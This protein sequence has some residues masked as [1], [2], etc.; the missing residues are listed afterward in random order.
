[1]SYINNP[2]IVT[3]G[4]VLSLDASDLNSYVSGSSTW[5][6]LS[7]NN[8]NGTL[9]N[10][11]RFQPT[12]SL[13]AIVFDGS[14]SFVS[15]TENANMTPQVLS[16]EA[17]FRVNS[18]TNSSYGGAPLTFQ[19][20]VFRQN[21]RIASFE[22][23]NLIYNEP[24]STLPNSVSVLCINAA[25]SGASVNSTTSSVFIGNTYTIAV[26]LNTTLTSIYING[27]FNTSG[28]KPSGLDY[29]VNHTLKLGRAVPTGTTFDMAFNGQ[30]Y[31]F[32]LY[33]RVL[34][35]SEVLQNYL[36]QKSKFDF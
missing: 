35:A 32:K 6:D 20:I 14:G 11:C 23:Y 10:S 25:G 5:S 12:S 1:M 2:K 16:F 9:F 17:T 34:S 22:G 15:I 24:T 21:S 4:L 18:A 7:G 28:T 8:N 31:N 33:N 13:G 30:I 19:Y 29:N 27:Q 26:T 36:T 3:N